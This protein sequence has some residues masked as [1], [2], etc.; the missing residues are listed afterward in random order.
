MGYSW[1]SYISLS[2][3]ARVEVRWWL[4]NADHLNIRGQNI[5][6][7]PSIIKVDNKLAGDGSTDEG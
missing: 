7:S 6:P 3:E 5:R 1:E 2:P 4:D